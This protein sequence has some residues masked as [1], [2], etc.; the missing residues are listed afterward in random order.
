MIF[1]VI[2]R[3]KRH[4]GPPGPTWAAQL[5][6]ID[7]TSGGDTA[8]VLN[9]P[10]PLKSKSYCIWLAGPL[11]QSTHAVS[12]ILTVRMCTL[13]WQPERRFCYKWVVKTRFCQKD[14]DQ[15]KEQQRHSLSC[16]WRQI[17]FNQSKTTFYLPAI[18]EC[19]LCLPALCVSCIAIISPL[20]MRRLFSIS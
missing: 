8:F 1:T 15:T 4:A 7:N 18:M 16:I 19:R 3:C 13:G 11:L 5:L 6:T 2:G 9:H 20:R 17:L 12:L 14:F 10:S